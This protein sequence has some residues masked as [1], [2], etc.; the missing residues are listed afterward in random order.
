MSEI[1]L[2]EPRSESIDDKNT[3]EIIKNNKEKSGED[4]Y[5]YL[6]RDNFTT[7]K[8]KIE[9]R[10]LP[11]YYG[12]GEFRRYL[13]EKLQLDAN[14]IKPPKRGSGWAYICFRSEEGREKAITAL[15]GTEWKKSKLSARIANP[16]PDPY[17]K[18]KLERRTETNNKISKIDEI[19][20]LSSEE[21]IK[22]STIPLCDMPYAEQLQ[23]KQKDMRQ[24]I[25]NLGQEISKV[26]KDLCEWFNKER[27]KHNELPFEL[28]EIKHAN[29]TE[30]YRNKCEFTVGM[31][32]QNEKKMIGF[33]LSS[34]AA[35]STAVGPIDHLCHIPQRMKTA[36]KILEKFVR[37]SELDV[38]DPVTHKG[39]WRQVMART[40]RLDHLML[41]IGIH[42]QDMKDEYKKKLQNDLKEF[43]EQD[44]N[45]EARVTSL[46]FQTIE[47]KGAGGTGGGTVEHISG[48]THIEEN[49]L[50]MTFR[51]SPEAF[52]QINTL[53]AEV[54]Y[55]TAI[56][57]AE[58]SKDTTLLDVCCGTGTIGLT[59]A[60]SCD[61]VLGIEMI[62]N[63]IND[64]KVNAEINNITN[65]DFFVG[66]AEDILVPVI[67]RTTKSNITAIVDPPRAGLHQKALVALRKAK[68]L[69]KLIYISCDPKAAVRNLVDLA[70]PNSKQY[71][72][73]PLVPIKAVPVDMFP[74]T[75]HCEL[76]LYLKRFSLLKKT[77]NEK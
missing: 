19:E 33:R 43:F 17:M 9:V 27:S 48:A 23:V 20:S 74:H 21:R 4:L 44:C 57:L 59:F 56:E 73:E 62:S 13:N 60:K 68:K 6:K 51:I 49:L 38:F 11:K 8:Y 24:V 40:T 2:E 22:L 61:Q 54:L 72:G 70:R 66:K 50:D 35:G 10:G 26:N 30:G 37:N 32:V 75:K 69:N 52:F 67:N 71:F 1:K 64:A 42:P 58:P 63:A 31:D 25:L 46:Y 39:Y 47:K 15:D 77:T 41:I 76:V 36:I 65:T 3:E 55:N 29:V 14:K 45:A 34:Y 12:I 53:G 7:E 28:G 5:G 16:A 18:R